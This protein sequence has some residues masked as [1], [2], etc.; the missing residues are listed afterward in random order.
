MDAMD[1]IDYSIKNLKTTKL[2][3][4]LTIIGIIIGV[5]TMVTI[6][7][8]SEGV[9]SQINNELSSFGP[10]KMFVIP[11]AISGGRSFGSPNKVAS[12]GKLFFKD[13][14]AI[15]NIIGV[16]SVAKTA[17]GRLTFGFK[18]KSLTATVYGIESVYFDQWENYL[19]IEFG[20][21]YDDTESRVAVLGY[22]AANKL[23]GK[24]KVSV[25][26]IVRIGNHDYRV[27]GILK[28]IGSSFSGADDASIYIPFD[29]GKDEL[30]SQLS[31]N[32]INF[33]SI[34]IEDGYSNKE[35]QEKV[36]SKLASLHKV[37]L[38]EKDF[39][40][41]TSDFVNQ[42]IGGLISGLAI[43]LLFITMIATLVGGIGIMNT[44]F[45]AVLERTNEIGVLKAL[46]ASE[47]EIQLIFVLESTILG[48]IGGIIGLVLGSILTLIIGS[49]GVPNLITPTILIFS[50]MFAVLVGLFA[51]L[52]P[53]NRA[54]KLDPVEALRYE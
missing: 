46:G 30:E 7:S 51:G 48:F 11:T 22:D 12:N 28:Q 45:M 53:S 43:F 41:I 14:D 1:I 42:T 35:I 21:V 13:A 34:S 20:R 44:M 39:S 26:S 15:E 17:Y 47:K 9:Q 33:I 6:S 23:F 32:E 4:Y 24:D 49:F 54:S 27:I 18:D 3:T 16:K 5:I 10:D 19:E 2:R 25:G 29:D 37:S 8:I 31:K 50:F 52:L 36:E 38:D 40:V